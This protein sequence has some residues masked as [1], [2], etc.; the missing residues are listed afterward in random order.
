MHSRGEVYLP[1][2]REWFARFRRLLDDAEIGVDITCDP[3]DAEGNRETFSVS[4]HHRGLHATYVKPCLAPD[5]ATQRVLE[6]LDTVLFAADDLYEYKC[7]LPPGP[8]SC[9]RMGPGPACRTHSWRPLP[10]G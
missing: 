1:L 6:C 10:M 7:R 9:W 8:A 2:T 5:A 4:D 3:A